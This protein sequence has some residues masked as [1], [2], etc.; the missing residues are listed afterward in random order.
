MSLDWPAI[1]RWLMGE[2]WVGSQIEQHLA[3]LCQQIGPRW[4][5]SDGERQ[6]V[7]YIREC[8][9]AAALARMRGWRASRWIRGSMGKLRLPS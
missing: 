9:E 1:D 2:A 6:A 8:M 3:V 7:A 4:S 5:S